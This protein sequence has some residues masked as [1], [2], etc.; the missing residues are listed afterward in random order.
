MRKNKLTCIRTRTTSRGLTIIADEIP[1]RGAEINW[2]NNLGTGAESS[3]DGNNTESWTCSLHIFFEIKCIRSNKEGEKKI[4][5]YINKSLTSVFLAG[6]KNG[7][8]YLSF[9]SL[10]LLAHTDRNR[11]NYVYNKKNT[12]GSV[13]N[14][15]RYTS[16]NIE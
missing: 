5:I 10:W 8:F 3:S 14:K 11:I 4:Y 1:A 2:I 12:D 15:Q 9:L 6:E 13:R 7:Q 16:K